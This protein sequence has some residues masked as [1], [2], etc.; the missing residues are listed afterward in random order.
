MTITLQFN[1][2]KTTP[3]TV[4]YAE[5]VPDGDPAVIRTMYLQKF[6]AKQLGNPDSITVT[7]DAFPPES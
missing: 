4:R 7:I 3:N 5:V 6:A 1:I 2:E